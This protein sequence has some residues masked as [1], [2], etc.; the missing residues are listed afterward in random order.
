MDTVERSTARIAAE[1]LVARA[2][3]LK[4]ALRERQRARPAGESAN[5]ADRDE[6]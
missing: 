6:Q 1:D 3:A 2:A 5:V 4:P